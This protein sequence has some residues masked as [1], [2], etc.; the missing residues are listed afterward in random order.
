[1]HGGEEDGEGDVTT[2]PLGDRLVEMVW[3]VPS[4]VLDVVE[5]EEEEDEEEHD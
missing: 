1:M 4:V 2:L 3:L 5:E